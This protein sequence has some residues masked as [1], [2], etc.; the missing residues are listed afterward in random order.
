MICVN[1]Y[2]S[3]TNIALGRHMPRIPIIKGL[4]TKLVTDGT[5]AYCGSWG[6]GLDRTS[7]EG[8]MCE[9]NLR[10]QF[11]SALP[12]GEALLGGSEGEGEGGIEGCVVVN[13]FEGRS[14]I[15]GGAAGGG[16]L[17][18]G[19]ELGFQPPGTLGRVGDLERVAMESG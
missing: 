15:L 6:D 17:Y 12:I 10:L 11:C 19:G 2:K 14:G 7:S 8:G 18:G 9:T 16:A 1:I 5:G 3:P 13:S 4:V